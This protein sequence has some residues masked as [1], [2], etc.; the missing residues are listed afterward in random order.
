MTILRMLP[1]LL[2]D[3]RVRWDREIEGCK[4]EDELDDADRTVNRYGVYQYKQHLRQ[5]SFGRS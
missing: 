5:I 1:K 2:Y 4:I 3:K